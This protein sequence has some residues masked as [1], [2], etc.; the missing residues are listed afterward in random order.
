MI[1]PTRTD[2][3]VDAWNEQVFIWHVQT[4]PDIGMSRLTGAWAV[5]IDEVGKV[6]LL[7]EKR[8]VLATSAGEKALDHICVAISQHIDPDATIKNLETA[9][10][11][12]QAVYDAHPKRQSLVAP[13]WPLL[14]DPIDM[15]NPP[16]AATGERTSVAL[17]VA[18]WLE[19]IAIT[20]EKIEAE[21]LARKYT[22]GDRTRRLT[23]IAV[24]MAGH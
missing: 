3:V 22:P 2:C 9:R 8:R 4:G 12:L 23:P 16:T 21:R 5:A 24:S 11:E 6:K 1:D 17:A 13:A 18:R 7:V 19:R 14:P 15:H 10:E 20:W